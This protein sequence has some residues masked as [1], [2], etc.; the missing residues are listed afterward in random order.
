M[1]PGAGREV[2]L[3]REMEKVKKVEKYDSYASRL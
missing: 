1:R 3:D 2:S